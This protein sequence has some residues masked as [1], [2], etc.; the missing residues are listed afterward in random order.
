MPLEKLPTHLVSVTHGK[1]SANKIIKG[2][3]DYDMPVIARVEDDKVLLDPRTLMDDEYEYV[4][5]ALA[6]LEQGV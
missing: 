2:L 3:R 6:S 4:A 1:L 5:K